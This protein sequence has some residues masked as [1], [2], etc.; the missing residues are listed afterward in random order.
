MCRIYGFSTY[1]KPQL[2]HPHT[3]TRTYTDKPSSIMRGRLQMCLLVKGLISDPFAQKKIKIVFFGHIYNAQTYIPTYICL[4]FVSLNVKQSNYTSKLIKVQRQTFIQ[5][6]DFD[7]SS[8][9][10]RLVGAKDE[11]RSHKEYSQ[12]K[13]PTHILG[14]RLQLTHEIPKSQ[15]DNGTRQNSPNRVSFI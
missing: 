4:K 2:K 6:R 11:H 7:C 1:S 12:Y 13:W 3:H 9:S 15:A 8:L 5:Y 10:N 14:T